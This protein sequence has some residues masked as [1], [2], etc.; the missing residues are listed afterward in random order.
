V[1]NPAVGVFFHWLGGF[2]S[3]SFYVP[4]KGVRNWSWETLW[5]VGGIFSWIVAPVAIGS[6]M[7][8]NLFAVLRETPPR[9]IFWCYLVG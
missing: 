4:F 3:G 5:T 1:P 8:N 6:L 2:A 7:T 9:T